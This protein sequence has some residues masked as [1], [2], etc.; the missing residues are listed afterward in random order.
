M[1][2]GYMCMGVDVCA[3]G[4]G[5]HRCGV[6]MWQCAWYKE[7]RA[8]CPFQYFF[9]CYCIWVCVPQH[10][11]R[12]QRTTRRLNLP[13]NQTL[14]GWLGWQTPGSCLCPLA[15]QSYAT[16]FSFY[17]C[18]GDSNNPCPQACM[19][20]AFLVQP[21]STLTALFSFLTWLYHVYELCEWQHCVRMSKI[22]HTWQKWTLSSRNSQTYR[23]HLFQWVEI[24]GTAIQPF[25]V[26]KGRALHALPR[27]CRLVASRIFPMPSVCSKPP[28]PRLPWEWPPLLSNQPCIV[29]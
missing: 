25:E 20:G 28:L 11:C 15:L 16:T 17:V 27:C 14:M 18:A 5:V 12:H 6:S 19:E 21:S 29:L 24:K 9:Y 10:V 4:C 8:Q 1:S 7:T 26:A 13:W 2:G 22:D 23:I 3:C